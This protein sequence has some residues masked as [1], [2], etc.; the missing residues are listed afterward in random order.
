M[1]GVSSY[2]LQGKLYEG[3]ALN[4]ISATISSVAFTEI[5]QT[6]RSRILELTLEL[7]KTIPAAALVTFGTPNDAEKNPEKIQQISQQIIYGDVSTAVAGGHGSNI[8]VAISERDKDSF[9]KHLVQSGIPENDAT[10][11]AQIVESEQPSSIEDPFGQNAKNWIASNLK[12][13]AEGTWN[14]G[15][16]VATTVLTEAALKFYG[17]K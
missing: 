16:S 12:K 14:V 2:L 8:S 15:I 10:E 7:E 1:S 6:V 17:L 4:S 13:A 11:F 5:L 9:I 3:Y